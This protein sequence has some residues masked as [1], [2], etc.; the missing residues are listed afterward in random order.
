[1][2]L[3]IE[4]TDAHTWPDEQLKELFS[5]GFPEFITADR[6]VKDYTGRVGEWFAI[7]DL[8]LVDEHEVPVA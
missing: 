8:T 7:P 4:R 6:L 1:M 3:K 5:D 2:A